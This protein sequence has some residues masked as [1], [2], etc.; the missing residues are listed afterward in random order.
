[1]VLFFDAGKYI[2]RVE[3]PRVNSS[4]DRREQVISYISKYYEM[5]SHDYIQKTMLS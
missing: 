1:M 5:Y 3:S 4:D 2:T